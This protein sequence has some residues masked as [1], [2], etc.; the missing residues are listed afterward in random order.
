MN[1]SQNAKEPARRYVS[2]A[3]LAGDIRTDMGGCPVIAPG[4]IAGLIA[5]SLAELRWCSV[6]GSLMRCSGANL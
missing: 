3:A 1:R 5:Y 2:V 4:E 6:N